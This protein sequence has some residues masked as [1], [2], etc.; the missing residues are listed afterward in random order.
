MNGNLNISESIIAADGERFR[1]VAISSL[2]LDTEPVFDLYFRPGPVQPFVLY[3]ERNHRIT[4]E[5]LQRLR[6]NR[7]EQLFV[8]EGE[9]GDYRRYLA[10]NM[11][12][13][14]SDVTISPREKAA[15]LY[16]STQSVLED[17]FDN[18]PTL[19]SIGLGKEVVRHTVTFMTSDEFLLEHLLRTI[20]TDYYLYS[21]SANVVAYSVA[22]AMRAGYCDA[23]TLR[24]IANGALLHDIGMSRIDPRLRN[25]PVSLTPDQWERVKQHPTEGHDMLSAVGSLGEI[26]LD[27][28]L[29][30]H[31][32]LNGQGYPHGIANRELSPFVRIV[33]MA[34]VFDALTTD[35]SHQPARKTFTALHVMQNEMRNEIDPDFFRLFV[36]MMGLRPSPKASPKV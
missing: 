17:V 8:R 18:P 24:E 9:L 2:C 5:S 32:K 20:S 3:S 23:P 7:I 12:T 34:N 11:G 36:E 21:H 25:A 14:L 4:D 6:D 19:E 22:L 31:E 15:I 33:T 10:A 26:A 16:L 27:I 13:I 29:H 35:R 30:H 1:P 28:V